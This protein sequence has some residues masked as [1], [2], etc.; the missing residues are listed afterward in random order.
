MSK[1]TDLRKVITTELNKAQGSTYYRRAPDNASFPYKVFTLQNVSLGDLSRDD[2]SLVVDVWDR[3]ADPKTAERIADRI[4]AI[5]NAVNLPQN[6]IFP[7]FFRDSRLVIDDDDK[8]IQR[9]QL[10]FLIQM[11]EGGTAT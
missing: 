9:I 3:A 5:L 1:T 11:Y 8:D 7:T 6:T 2:F 4:E 10:S